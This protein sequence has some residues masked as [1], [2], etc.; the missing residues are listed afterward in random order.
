MC[1]LFT[2]VDIYKLI[3]SSQS[4]ARSSKIAK[5]LWSG[6]SGQAR[7]GSSRATRQAAEAQNHI[8]D[9]FI[10]SKSPNNVHSLIYKFGG[11]NSFLV[12]PNNMSITTA[13]VAILQQCRLM[14]GGPGFGGGSLATRRRWSMDMNLDNSNVPSISRSISEGLGYG[15]GF[16][17]PVPGRVSSIDRLGIFGAS[18][19]HMSLSSSTSA[20]PT[21][22]EID[23]LLAV[24]PDEKLLTRE[25]DGCEVE[26][27]G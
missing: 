19:V 9:S 13:V 14:S 22:D 7:K 8:F 3:C 23:F 15:F 25:G 17:L 16:G 11:R 27:G 12:M 24:T 1:V 26:V 5:R 20:G 2:F 4:L 21:E 6:A 10:I 18:D